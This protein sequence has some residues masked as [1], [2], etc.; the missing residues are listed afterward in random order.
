MSEDTAASQTAIFEMLMESQH[1]SADQMLAFQH[2]QLEQ[3]LRHAKATVPFYKSRLDCLF[4]PDGSIDWKRWQDVPVLIRRDVSENFAALQSTE[5]PPG[6]GKIQVA[7]TSGSTGL[8]I[9]VSYTRLLSDVCKAM[10]WR[11]HAAWGLDWSQ[12]LVYWHKYEEKYSRFGSHH[13]YGPWG[14][15]TVAKS[16]AGRSYVANNEDPLADRLTHLR[17]VDAKYIFTQGNFTLAAAIE[18]Q[19]SGKTFPLESVVS[20]GIG[21]D[22]QFS[23]AIAYAFGAKLFALYSS[24]E[25]GRLAHLCGKCE[26]Y[27]VNTEM[28]HLEILDDKDQP[29]PP[30]V[31]GRVI[32][33]NFFN[34]AQ[35]FIRYEQG[36]IATWS[37]GC[38]CGSRLPALER[39]DGR[40]YHLFRRR[41]GIVYAPQVTDE[42]RNELGASF[43][44][45]VQID[46]DTI[47]VK[48]KPHSLRDPQRETRFASR[49]R[50]ILTEDYKIKFEVINSLPLTSS[51]KFLKYVYDAQK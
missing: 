38:V 41:N 4:K 36:D 27:H 14:P 34:A 26:R 20:H 46:A 21:V 7:S 29:C 37:E 9:S 30:G 35:P 23:S 32:I 25:G 13:N 16:A 17:E 44:Q 5:L 50:D 18:M 45:F 11:A 12:S 51:G 43:W 3:L 28:V 19:E 2:S 15:N 42:F 10:D 33:T 8:P 47:V 22:P 48:Y 39:I 1:W 31:A 6:H 24:K 40:I 49:L